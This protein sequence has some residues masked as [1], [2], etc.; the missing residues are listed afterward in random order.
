MKAVIHMRYGDPEVLQVATIE[1][2][3]PQKNEVLVHVKAAGLDYG[4]WHLMSGKPYVMRLATGL[5]K[6]KQR[7]QIGR[8]HV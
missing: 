4:Q 5:T 8:A 7:V 3:V 6:P 1:R 2:P